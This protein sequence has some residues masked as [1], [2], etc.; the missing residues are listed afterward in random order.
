MTLRLHDVFVVTVVTIPSCHTPGLLARLL[1]KIHE[2][3]AARCTQEIPTFGTFN[4]CFEA[5]AFAPA[6]CRVLQVLPHWQV[7]GGVCAKGISG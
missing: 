2:A 6:P 3:I 1:M 5:S 7:A 4:A